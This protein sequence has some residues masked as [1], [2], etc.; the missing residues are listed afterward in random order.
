[1]KGNLKGNG[2]VNILRVN[3]ANIY[4]INQINFSNDILDIFQILW[5]RTNL[6]TAYSPNNNAP[7]LMMGFDLY[8]YHMIIT[9]RICL[10]DEHGHELRR[11]SHLVQHS[12]SE[13][14]FLRKLDFPSFDR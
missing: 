1:V 5:E 6:R 11:A 9:S 7:G 10:H 4:M 13:I 14:Y 2:R 12:C 3:F 8:L